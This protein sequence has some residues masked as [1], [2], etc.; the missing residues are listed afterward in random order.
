MVVDEWRTEAFQ[1]VCT[2]SSAED[3]SL[4]SKEH[5]RYCLSELNPSE[6]ASRGAKS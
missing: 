6:I 1:A 2:E 5:W 3:R 4:W